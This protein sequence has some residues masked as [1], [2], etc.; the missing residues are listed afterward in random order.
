MLSERAFTPR[1]TLYGGGNKFLSASAATAAA[2]GNSNANNQEEEQNAASQPAVRNIL[3]FIEKYDRVEQQEL[4]SQ[5]TCHWLLSLED[6]KLP[7][8]HPTGLISTM[9]PLNDD[10]LMVMIPYDE[11]TPDLD[12]RELHQVIRELTV[13]MYVLNQHPS[14]Q[15]ETNFDESTAC[16]LPPAYI[17][18]KLGQIM[19][20]T[21]YWLKALWHG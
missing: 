5:M 21:D 11:S 6:F 14:L 7:I 16:Q 8:E 15:L 19:I 20:N 10:H 17:D 2:G 4:L 1:S 9:S 12:Y 18:T 3:G 13:G